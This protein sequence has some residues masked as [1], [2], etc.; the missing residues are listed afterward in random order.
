M[1]Y[2]ETKKKVKKVNTSII[3]QESMIILSNLLNIIEMEN[4]YFCSNFTL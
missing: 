3:K 2:K 1:F 4:D